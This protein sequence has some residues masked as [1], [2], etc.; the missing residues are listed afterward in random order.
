MRYYIYRGLLTW[1]SSFLW[2][3]IDGDGGT[4]LM[5]QLLL[6]CKKFEVGVA[7]HY[8]VDSDDSEIG[9]QLVLDFEADMRNVE[10]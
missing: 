8:V 9:S 3:K 1:A 6:R 10:K 4:K 2:F 5:D 7:Q